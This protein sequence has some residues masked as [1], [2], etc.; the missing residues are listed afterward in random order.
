MRSIGLAGTGVP[1]VSRVM[2]LIEQHTVR[3]H[4]QGRAAVHDERSGEP[5]GDLVGDRA[6]VV[7]VIPVGA[8]RVVG[9]DADQ[10]VERGA[11]VDPE[12]GVVAVA[13]RGDAQP[14]GVQVGGLVQP[15][16]Q[17]DGEL[18]TGAHPQRGTG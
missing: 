7:G 18:V 13:L 4:G 3:G 14:V 12:E 10:V 2:S 16:G 17:P 1:V 9:G 5:A 6:V 11:G 8:R 15:V